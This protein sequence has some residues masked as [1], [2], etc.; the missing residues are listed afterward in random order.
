MQQKELEAIERGAVQANARPR[1]GP[2]SRR[3]G[4]YA[5][6]RVL[7][8]QAPPG[9][10]GNQEVMVEAPLG[11]DRKKHLQPEDH[12]LNSGT[13]D[14]VESTIGHGRKHIDNFAERTQM[15]GTQDNYK[16]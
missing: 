14:A 9:D 16:A 7:T 2:E 6:S 8:S 13:A 4:G 1:Q 15:S 12:M 11:G 3:S 10:P 5:M